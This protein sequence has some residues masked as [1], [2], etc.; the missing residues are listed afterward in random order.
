[1]TW[2]QPKSEAAAGI[3]HGDVGFEGRLAAAGSINVRIVAMTPS[4]TRPQFL[5]T[6][7]T[8]ERRR[9]LWSQLDDVTYKEEDAANTEVLRVPHTLTKFLEYHWRGKCSASHGLLSSAAL[10][11]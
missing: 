5:T 7:A 1:M 6:I 4:T 2:A 11:A 10:P 3:L 8:V 9:I